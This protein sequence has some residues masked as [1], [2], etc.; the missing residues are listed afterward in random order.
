VKAS[1][2][3]PAAAQP[4]SEE[5]NDELSVEDQSIPRID[6]RPVQFAKG[7]LVSVDCSQAPVAIVTFSTGAK[8]MKLRTE[9]CKALLL[10]NADQFSCN[11]ANRAASVN[12]K[13]GGKSDGDLVSL[14]L[15]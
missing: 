2:A 6:R 7:R 15:H 4:V 3:P 12:Y 5:Q 9:N 8:T 14:E 11:W 13:A 10:I 1:P